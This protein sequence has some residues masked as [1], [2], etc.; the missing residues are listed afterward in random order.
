MVYL[1]LVVFALIWNVHTSYAQ[2]AVVQSL[3]VQSG[4]Y[5]A[6]LVAP[7]LA[8]DITITMPLTSG[9]LVSSTDAWMMGGQNLLA[10]PSRTIGSTNAQSIQLVSNNVARVHVNQSNGYVGIGTTTPG[11]GLS[12]D[13]A[14][15][16]EAPAT[17]D[18][19]TIPLGDPLRIPI[20]NRS[21]IVITNG[22]GGNYGD[23]TDV[24]IED[25]IQDG[26]VV[27]IVSLA[28]T[29]QT[30]RILNAELNVDLNANRNLEGG[31]TIMLIWYK[32]AAATGTWYEVMRRNNI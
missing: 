12:I 5:R 27:T 14:L 25:G 26:Q 15:S 18:I 19:E 22:A 9:T 16:T 1:Y 6:T 8:S 13:G 3:S 10:G 24:S 32:G 11:V 4:Q 20:G 23:N 31:N 7:P 28:G 29:T 2:N 30:I 21:F 17:F